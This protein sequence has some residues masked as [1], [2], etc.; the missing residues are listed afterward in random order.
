MIADEL[1][2][3]RGAFVVIGNA[4][5]C[6]IPIGCIALGQHVASLDA[7]PRRLAFG[8]AD[9][10]YEYFFVSIDGALVGLRDSIAILVVAAAIAFAVDP[11]LVKRMPFGVRAPVDVMLSM[12]SGY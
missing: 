4:G 11:V 9:A 1:L 7:A 6:R 5:M 8:D 12:C 3:G 10:A 2:A